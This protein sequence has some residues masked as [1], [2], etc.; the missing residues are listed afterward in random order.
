[1]KKLL[2][3]IRDQRGAAVIEIAIALPV[4][5]LF[6]WGIFQLGIAFQAIAG[7][8][9]ALGEGARLATVC[10]N[11]TAD[12]VCDTATDLEIETRVNEQLFGTGLGEF[13]VAVTRVPDDPST[14][15][16]NEAATADYLT[17]TTTFAMTPNF[18]LFDGPVVNLTRTK[19]VYIA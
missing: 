9:H 4:L 1:M 14:P 15:A 16:V 11:P 6:L 12:G 5:V 2:P 10:K 18:L 7:M 17:L 13:D 19:K 3:S 8:Q